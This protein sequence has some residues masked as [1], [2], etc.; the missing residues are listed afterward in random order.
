M[1]GVIE[2]TVVDCLLEVG[3]QELV[4][5]VFFAANIPPDRVYRMDR[6]Y[7]DGETG[8]LINAVLKVTG[9]TPEQLFELFAK[10][11][12]EV[13]EDVFPEFLRMSKTSEDLVR[14]QAKIHALIAAGGRKPG[15]SNKSTDK[16]QLEDRGPNEI[17]VRYQSE[18]QLCG[19]YQTLVGYAADLFGDTVLIEHSECA[20]EGA[21][22]CKIHV[23]WTS[24]AGQPTRFH[25]TAPQSPPGQMRYG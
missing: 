14:K 24:I 9:L 11:F 23:K 21:E 1:I 2:K 10:V 16:F 13:V 18:L 5:D 22:F 8:R 7:P 6:H 17:A 20:H 12:F 15:E 4:Q 19:L 25:P 3:D